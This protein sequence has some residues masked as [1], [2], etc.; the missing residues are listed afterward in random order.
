MGSN[1]ARRCRPQGFRDGR[2]AV[3]AAVIVAAQDT[4]WWVGLI[5]GFAVVAVV[6]VIAAIL[7]TLAAR[8]ADNARQASAALPVV[9]DQ[10]TALQ[11]VPRINE[12]A[13]SV[14]RSARA[15]RKALTGS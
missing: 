12:S 5:A 13:I 7:L 3:V 1:Q 11:D 6:V 14:L 15:A 8:I 9:R 2:S 10:T 4:G